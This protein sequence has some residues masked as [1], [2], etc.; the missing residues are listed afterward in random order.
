MNFEYFLENIL[1]LPGKNIGLNAPL[2]EPSDEKAIPEDTMF[3]DQVH[4]HLNTIDNSSNANFNFRAIKSNKI[5]TFS[6]NNADWQN[7][8][9]RYIKN[10]YELFVVVNDTDGRGV[11]TANITGVRALFLDLDSTEIDNLAVID[12]LPLAPNLVVNTS[13]G[14]F[15]VYWSVKDCALDKFNF[16]QKQLAKNFH[17]DP[18]VCD[19]PRIMRLAGSYH[20][21]SE[22]FFVNVI[23]QHDEDYTLSDFMTAFNFGSF[24]SAQLGGIDK[25]YIEENVNNRKTEDENKNNIQQGIDLHNSLLSLAGIWA[26]KG[27]TR[28]II[29]KQLQSLMA[30]SLT[31]R[32]ERYKTRVDEIPRIVTYALENTSKATVQNGAI[33]LHAWTEPRPL[34]N[35]LKAVPALDVNLLPKVMQDLVTDSAERMQCPPDFLAAGMIVASSSIIA[36]NIVVQPKRNDVGWLV[37]LNLW[38]AIIGKPSLLKSPT[39]SIAMNA[40]ERLEWEAREM[41]SKAQ[42]EHKVDCEIVDFR[43]SQN[44]SKVKELIGKG[45]ISEA[46]AILLADEVDEEDIPTQNRYV[47]N[48]GTI[49]KIADL[50]CSNTKGFLVFR[51]ELSGWFNNLNKPDK[52]NDRS[53]ML[54]SWNGD[55]PYSIDRIGRGTTFIP[56]NRLSILGGIQPDAFAKVVDETIKGSQGGDGLL[57][58]FQIAVY[59][60]VSHNNKF[61]D[62][63]PNKTAMNEF[64]QALKSLSEWSDDRDE[65]LT[66]KFNDPAYDFFKQWFIKNEAL[67][68]NDELSSAL[69]SHYAKYRGLVPTIAAIFYVLENDAFEQDPYINEQST[70]NAIAYVEYLRKHAERIYALPE[71]VV[72][73]GAKTILSKFDKLDDNFFE[74]TVK[75]KKWGGLTD[76][77]VVVAALALLEEHGYCMS[78]ESK[79]NVGRP[80]TYFVKHPKYALPKLPKLPKPGLDHPYNNNYEGIKPCKN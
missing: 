38:G 28:P 49:E 19:L 37:Y 51:D 46:R 33:P 73:K 18:S 16:I 21:K 76:D 64:N 58:R 39:L 72:L 20:L 30:A 2:S 79:S 71:Q 5:G 74:R 59:P 77:T 22:P 47:I 80:T 6:S 32:D 31:V 75:R 62:Q 48:D 78:I 27:L 25:N 9:L 40:L 44:K 4:R 36:R 7:Q 13:P 61:I 55:K 3:L 68:R 26:H 1:Q 57:Q 45:N 50:L 69:E 24:D 35:E 12:S 41:F 11:K 53:F 29:I 70:V 66:L 65:N 54:E 23:S 43:A 14:K 60:D 34:K 63:A 56:T 42:V 17:G 67:T 15:H 52:T 10:N 8:V